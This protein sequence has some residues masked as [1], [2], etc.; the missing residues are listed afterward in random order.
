M[1]TLSMIPDQTS[2]SVEKLPIRSPNDIVVVRHKVRN[3]ANELRLSLIDQTK[4]V[5]A[6][7]ELARNTLDYGGGGE[8]LIERVSN[9]LKRGVRLEFRD[10]GP[11]IADLKLALTDGYTTGN[12]LGMG[13]SGSKRLMDDFQIVSQP[14]KGTTVSVTKWK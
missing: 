10:Q 4:V 13:L 7:S 5:T 6:A 11:G 1:N 9:G 3:V 12:G 8:V 14:G 2:A